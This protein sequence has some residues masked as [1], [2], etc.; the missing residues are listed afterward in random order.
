MMKSPAILCAVAVYFGAKQKSIETIK[1][2]D[3]TFLSVNLPMLGKAFD[4]A[5]NT[6]CF[7]LPR[8]FKP[9]GK[10]KLPAFLYEFFILVFDKFGYIRDRNVIDYQAI[11]HIRQLLY[12]FYKFESD[13]SDEQRFLAYEKFKDVDKLVK[14]DFTVEQIQ[15]LEPI[16]H[17]LFPDYT[18]DLRPMHS[19]GA[20]SL[21]FD[22]I[23]R[24]YGKHLCPA[25][26]AFTHLFFQ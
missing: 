22:N 20:T 6:G 11:R 19:N 10:T 4:A 26:Q 23:T 13:F 24:K 3:S 16:F 9:S 17:S 18:C 21:R 1:S 15:L 5:L 14:N 7:V 8:G 2:F 12:L 25:T